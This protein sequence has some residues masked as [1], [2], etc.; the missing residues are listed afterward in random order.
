MQY[1]GGKSRLG[2][3]I[4]DAINGYIGETNGIVYEPFCGGCGVTPYL[5]HAFPNVIASD[6][7]KDLIM[8][9][10]AVKDGWI[11]PNAVSE[12]EYKELR[13][14]PS[15]PLRGFV[16]FGCSWG[17]KWFGGYAR[18]KYGQNYAATSTR[19]IEKVR[20]KLRNVEFKCT[21]YNNITP[22]TGDVVYCDP[23]YRG[24]TPYAEQDKFNH[25]EF[26]GVVTEW[27]KRGVYVFVSEFEAP[28]DWISIW[29]LQRKR[30]IRGDLKTS[31]DVID[32]L[33]VYGGYAPSTTSS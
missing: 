29:G 22:I 15:S 9:W 17:G 27:S 14:A 2:K 18:N 10:N 13:Y 11:P 3:D 28:S 12:E 16:G 8:M 6:T 24:T 7:H 19:S 4:V 26:W 30:A 1:L 31:K 32:R 5:A 33:F 25:D 20:C 23:P 21:S